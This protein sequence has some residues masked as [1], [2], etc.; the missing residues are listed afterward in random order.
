MLENWQLVPWQR[1]DWSPP[2]PG[3]RVLGTE[4]FVHKPVLYD[5]T[6]DGAWRSVCPHPVGVVSTSP[7]LWMPIRDVA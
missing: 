7:P 3:S 6:L 4:S 1:T 5:Y 2:C